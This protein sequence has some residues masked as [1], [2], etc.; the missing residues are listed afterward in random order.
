MEDTRIAKIEMT[1]VLLLIA[2]LESQIEITK[3]FGRLCR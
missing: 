2:T 1:P 3:N